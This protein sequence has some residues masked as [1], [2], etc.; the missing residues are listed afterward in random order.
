MSGVV[1]L[2]ANDVF[3]MAD[4]FLSMLYTTSALPL[5]YAMSVRLC[6]KETR[7]LSLHKHANMLH[8]VITHITSIYILLTRVIVTASL[9]P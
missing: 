8:A 2:D 5:R 3:T 7:F 6:Q 9:G 1:A 4:S